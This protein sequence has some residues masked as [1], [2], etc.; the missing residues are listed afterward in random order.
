MSREGH[1]GVG[2]EELTGA[3]EIA[4]KSTSLKDK[5]EEPPPDF[6]EGGES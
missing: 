2:E 3:A 1:A 4:I 6:A 5:G